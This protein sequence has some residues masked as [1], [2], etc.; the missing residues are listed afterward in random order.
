M[1]LDKKNLGEIIRFGI[2][3]VFA[4]LLHYGIYWVLMHYINV[5]VAYTL[6]YVL[7]LICNFFLTSYFT[8][9][10][11]AS[12]GKSIGFGGAHLVNY[13][14]HICLLNLFL[15]LGLSKSI[16]PI[17]VYLI[18]IPV[19]FILVRTVFKWKSN[20]VPPSSAKESE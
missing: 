15:Y 16:A 4:T 14:L 2:V 9:K 12:I 11:K 18:V 17:P 1:T 13:L 20:R 5:N 7:S 6:G 10:S 8:F 3:G 19:N